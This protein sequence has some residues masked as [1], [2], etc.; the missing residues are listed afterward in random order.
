MI[1]KSG[2]RLSDKIMLQQK[3]LCRICGSIIARKISFASKPVPLRG[4]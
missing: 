1:R 2:F 3:A 4:A